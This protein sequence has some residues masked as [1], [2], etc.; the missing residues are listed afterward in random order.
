MLLQERSYEYPDLK[1]VEEM[2]EEHRGYKEHRAARIAVKQH[3]KDH[4]KQKVKLHGTL[5][6]RDPPSDSMRC[7]SLNPVETQ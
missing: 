2:V 3:D 4:K 5:R 7:M 6:P 1:E